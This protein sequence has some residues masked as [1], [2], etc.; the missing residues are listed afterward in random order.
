MA[1]RMTAKRISKVVAALGLL[2]P[3]GCW[4]YCFPTASY[5]SGSCPS[6]SFIK[7]P[8][9][10]ESFVNY[11]AVTFADFNGD[12][13]TDMA[14]AAL[15]SG[16][17]GSV[18]VYLGD[19]AGGF[20][21]AANFQTG[22]SNGAWDIVSADFNRDGKPDLVTANNF[23]DSVSLLLGNG[24]GG[25]AGAVKFGVGSGPRSIAVA[26][27]NRDGSLDVATINFF[28]ANVSV[29][30]G[31]GAGGFGSARTV[32]VLANPLYLKAADFNND[33][34]PDLAV[35]SQ[36]VNGISVLLGDGAG[37][38]APA[39]APFGVPNRTTLGLD[40]ADFDKDGLLDLAVVNSS[41]PPEVVI[42]R[43]DGTG[44]FSVQTSIL[45]GFGA[46]FVL[47]SDFDADGQAD[48]LITNADAYTVSII[49]GLGGGSFA[50]QRRF[51]AGMASPVYAAAGDFNGDG[52]TDVGVVDVLRVSA[53]LG[54]GAGGFTAPEA[55]PVS[56]N[57][58]TG[59][60]SLAEGD[61]N[62]DGKVD[63]AVA[64]D[65][66]I[67]ALLNDGAGR[68][69]PKFSGPIAASGQSGSIAAADF[70]RDGKL[71]V[72]VTAGAG[73]N[74]VS[75]FLG[76]GAGGFTRSS[77][78]QADTSPMSLYV[79]DFNNDGIDDLLTQTY[80]GS[81][82]SVLLGDGTGAFVRRAVSGLAGQQRVVAVGDFNG[83]G[84]ADL[85]GQ[86]PTNNFPSIPIGVLLGDGTGNFSPSQSGTFTAG[87]IPLAMLVDDFNG[88]GKTDLSISVS[89]FTS[90][91]TG[92][93][94]VPGDGAG[95]LGT[96]SRI[97]DARAT[98]LVSGDFNADGS[99]DVAAA[100]GDVVAVV[101]GDGTGN[102]GQPVQFPVGRTPHKVIAAD[103]NG[104]GKTD[105]ATANA[106]G[107][108]TLLLNT[109]SFAS[110]PPAL[111][112]GDASV[113]EGDGG[114]VNTTFTV[115]LSAA[116]AKT[117]AV[118][119][120]AFPSGQAAAG[121]DFQPVA[122]SLVFNPGVT[123]RTFTVSVAGDT[124]DEF[125][126]KFAVRLRFPLNAGVA[127]E[128][129]EGTIVDD[130][131]P[132]SASVGDASLNEGNGGTTAAVF[133]VTLSVPSGRPVSIPYSTA[134][135][136]AAAVADYLTTTGTVTF[137]PGETSRTVSVPVLGDAVYESDENFFVNL[138]VP[139]GATLADA[140]G[141][142][143]I[144]ND[145][146]GVRFGAASQSVGEGAGSVGI[147]VERFGPLSG[148]STVSYATADGT[149]S[150]RSD[151]NL[152]LGTLRFAPGEA[153]K[154]ITVLITDDR[155]AEG[156]ESF[157]VILSDP[158][159][160]ST[161]APAALM[162]QVV[163]NDG[164]D[165]PS[166]VRW[167]TSFDPLFFVRQHYHD[168]LNR[169]PDVTG[170]NFW[171]GQMTGCGNPNVEVCRVNVSA[172]F[173]LSIEFRETGYLVERMYKAAFGDANGVTRITG[174]AVQIPVPVV[175][176]AEFLADSKAIGDG[177]I[178]GQDGWQ[179]ALEDNKQAFALAFV[180]R[181]RFASAY[182]S[183]MT[184]PQFVDALFLNARVTPTAAERDAA[185]AAF[186]SGGAA[187]RAAALRTVAQSATFDAAERNRAFVLMQYFGYLQRDPDAAPDADHTGYQFW[188]DK[189]DQHHGDF[190]EA[191]MVR[192]FITSDEYRKRFGQ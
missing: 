14:A 1:K 78:T 107:D 19:G 140:Q 153:S 145:D 61:Y 124:L 64:L 30:L 92:T 187:G 149:A 108:V 146:A 161:A 163:D 26:D 74:S 75:A 28:S 172:A 101:P 52:R 85:V 142:A 77:V 155:L 10:S 100:S 20:G 136:S 126:E 162:V 7:A 178:V 67:M 58:F 47:V 164:S 131:P 105:L 119:Y 192:A 38:F 117:V 22:D 89:T 83:D 98:S 157:G 113:A 73:A 135:G 116:S 183:G 174:A 127:R 46:R 168:F 44:R 102:F 141:A 81:A 56:S 27:F 122:G 147:A 165:A 51:A 60:V 66:G 137:S 109:C 185:V 96:A 158:A 111:T 188:L 180:Q 12:G 82:D 91:G 68:F 88:D 36:N 41:G 93:F 115:Q 121:A 171:T 129:A 33:G 25:F 86:R 184:A 177:I 15:A 42:W 65:N 87:D 169:E 5:A 94:I 6:P 106:S 4:V 70:N 31:D 43:G 138:G 40:V 182:P 133:N 166:P 16:F 90:S 176:R 139:D 3:L 32:S 112:V 9:V 45:A 128:V 71:D 37:N 95:G 21:S 76:D 11:R 2:L 144:V 179:Q 23:S 123:S 69:Q 148:V 160:A 29:L 114:A 190:V 48:L 110:E 189:L 34:K 53:L 191:E 167:D 156:D 103:L 24:S 54:D 55:F 8:S 18:R 151:Y 152:A 57:S 49:R 186:G 99:T 125:D 97:Y 35:S 175:R 134:D 39:S 132:P 118:D 120:Y 159:G 63:L 170:L 59:A 181:Q 50:P 84:N 104:D 154:T 143:T 13:K 130:D 80:G 17:S 79:A 150:E 173:F 62:S 72:A